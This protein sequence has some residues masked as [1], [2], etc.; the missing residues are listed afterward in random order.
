MMWFLKDGVLKKKKKK[1]REQRERGRNERL[2]TVSIK[3]R[4]N[5][6]KRHLKCNPRNKPKTQKGQFIWSLKWKESQGD[7]PTI[8]DSQ[9][10]EKSAVLI[11][12]NQLLCMRSRLVQMTLS[13]F[14]FPF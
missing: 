8:S 7:S 12:M 4:K 13:N 9:W 14:N 11:A 10:T 3:L 6:S 5:F 2:G 1:S